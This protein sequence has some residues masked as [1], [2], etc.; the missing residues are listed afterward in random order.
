MQN[1]YFSDFLHVNPNYVHDEEK[2]STR[3]VIIRGIAASGT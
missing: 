1:L 3:G 2:D